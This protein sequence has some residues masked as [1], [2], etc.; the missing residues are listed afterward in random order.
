MPTC[1]LQNVWT[2]ILSLCLKHIYWYLATT[3]EY[4]WFHNLSLVCM[5]SSVLTTF[6]FLNNN[7]EYRL[8]H[9]WS[10]CKNLGSN[11]GRQWEKVLF[12]KDIWVTVTVRGVNRCQAAEKD[13]HYKK[14]FYE[15]F[16]PSFLYSST[17]I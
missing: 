11:H 5:Y 2:L 6:M 10:L 4:S 13:N 9:S 17:L 8:I 7:G 15:S 3:K 16:E 1:L 12:K 14:S